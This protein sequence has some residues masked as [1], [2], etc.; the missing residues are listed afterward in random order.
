MNAREV[1]LLGTLAVAM[2][3]VGVIWLTPVVVYPVWAPVGEPER[4]ADH[5]A[6][7][8]RLPGVAFI[9]HGQDPSVSPPSSRGS[10]WRV[11][12]NRPSSW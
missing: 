3:N 8:R 1:V 11:N 9:P 5:E 10:S 4:N 12:R 7:K 2:F 6:H